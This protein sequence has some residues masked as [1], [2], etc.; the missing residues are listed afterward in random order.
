MYHEAGFCSH[1][2]V[3]STFIV[4]K[5]IMANLKNIKME[6]IEYNSTS[7]ISVQMSPSPAI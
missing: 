6:K 4:F 7:N 5:I 2:H 3:K 1:N